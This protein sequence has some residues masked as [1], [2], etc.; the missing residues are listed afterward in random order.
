MRNPVVMAEL[1]WRRIALDFWL[2]EGGCAAWLTQRRDEH[3]W[4]L[5]VRGNDITAREDLREAMSLLERLVREA[6]ANG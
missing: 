6:G 5:V 1:S 3:H 4:T 2:L